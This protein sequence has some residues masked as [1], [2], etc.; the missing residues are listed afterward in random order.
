MEENENKKGKENK[1][2]NKEETIVTNNDN[3]KTNINYSNNCF[4]RRNMLFTY[5]YS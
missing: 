2:E 1:N 4:N 3:K 5:E